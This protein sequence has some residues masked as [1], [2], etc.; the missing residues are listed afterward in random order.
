[1]NRFFAALSA[2]AWPTLSFQFDFQNH[3]KKW[4]TDLLKNTAAGKQFKIFEL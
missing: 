3:E 4:Q 2:F 1:M